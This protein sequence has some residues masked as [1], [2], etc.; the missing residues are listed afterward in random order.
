MMAKDELIK[1]AY[2]GENPERFK[3]TFIGVLHSYIGRDYDR[4]MLAFVGCALMTGDEQ[5]DKETLEGFLSTVRQR[6][7]SVWEY[8]DLEFY[9][10]DYAMDVRMLRLLMLLHEVILTTQ[11]IE[12]SVKM[13]L[14]YNKS[15]EDFFLK[16]FAN[17]EVDDIFS[18]DENDPQTK[19]WTFLRLMVRNAPDLH[20]W[21]IMKLTDLLIPIDEK[22][23]RAAKSLGITSTDELTKNNQIRITNYFRFV[24][25]EDPVKGYYAL[26]AYSDNNKA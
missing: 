14:R 22:I 15:V 16:L 7:P 1:L 2:E 12:K 9:M 25:H 4:E 19:I 5:K 24:F 11:T 13:S 6:T 3:N 20:Q 26:L 10:M 17:A 21:R 18:F 23:A 8:I